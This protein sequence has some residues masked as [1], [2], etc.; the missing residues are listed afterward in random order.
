[1]ISFLVL[2]DG[3]FQSESF[4]PNED[5]R[6][7]WSRRDALV[8]I[9]HSSCYQTHAKWNEITESVVLVFNDCSEQRSASEQKSIG[10]AKI[11]SSFFCEEIKDPIEAKVIKKLRSSFK[12]M[13]H[14]P[15]CLSSGS[16]VSCCSVKMT[17][18]VTNGIENST[19]NVSVSE[20]SK[21]DI[22][23]LLQSNCSI[24]FLRKYHLNG[25]ED[26]VLKKVNKTIITEAYEEFLNG[27]HQDNSNGIDDQLTNSFKEI[28]SHLLRKE[29]TSSNPAGDGSGSVLLK[30]RKREEKSVSPPGN[31]ENGKQ[32]IV[33]LL[34]EDYPNELPVYKLRESLQ[35]YKHNNVHIICILG[36]VRDI[37][38]DETKAI[39]SA[40][41]LLNISCKGAN[42]GRTAEFT[43]KIITAMVFHGKSGALFDAVQDL[44]NVN[45]IIGT[46]GNEL[47]KL[48][49]IR[50]NHVT[51]DGHSTTKSL[52]M[53]DHKNSTSDSSSSLGLSVKNHLP[54]VCLTV[55]ARVPVATNDI[56]NHFSSSTGI[57]VD[58]RLKLHGLIQLIIS[59]LWRS[60]IGS[61]NASSSGSADRDNEESASSSPLT[62]LLYLV[63]ED[64]I[65][66]RIDESM[67]SYQICQYHMS[68]PSEYQILQ[69]LIRL[70]TAKS[71]DSSF[72]SHLII[73]GGNNDFSS[74]YEINLLSVIFDNE[75]KLNGMNSK[76]R[77]GL[78]LHCHS[79]SLTEESFKVNM[80]D[81]LYQLAYNAPCGCVSASG[82]SAME[83][84]NEGCHV[85]VLFGF[86][87]CSLF[88]G[89][90]LYDSAWVKEFCKWKYPEEEIASLKRLKKKMKKMLNYFKSLDCD[91]YSPSLLVSL[92][93]QYIYHHRFVSAVEQLETCVDSK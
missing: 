58:K 39:L 12:T 14:F 63:F 68:A 42:L 33:L 65:V 21:K 20:M 37:T 48:P 18:S 57:D 36:A 40:C 23:R 19:S 50:Q 45:A 82:A 62:N 27:K 67:I 13:D 76:K 85:F 44:P 84:R 24:E 11:S 87:L 10:V 89:A 59:T 7:W 26:L 6:Q 2:C 90:P 66:L 92:F 93:Q 15:N 30:K 70:L 77:N 38:G 88:T 47:M 73:L 16:S 29:S 17:S 5:Q 35:N 79:G 71:D 75:N 1:M 25:N 55:V 54:S 41:N 22:V 28:F 4:R 78:I 83:S 72:N 61:M 43:S 81:G 80:L 86:P 9:V 52:S 3:P 53:K 74:L 32:L 34:H 31:G 60:R 51:W 69:M 46:E 56:L 49:S 8:R 91:S 64:Q